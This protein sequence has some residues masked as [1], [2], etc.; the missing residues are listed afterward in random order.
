MRVDVHQHLWTEPLLEALARRRSAPFVRRRDGR[1]RLELP[2]EEA[3]E[4]PGVPEDLHRRHGLLERDGIDRAYVA[5]SPALGV[6]ALPADEADEL[7]TAFAAGLAE[8]GPG[9]HP[10]AAVSLAD[11][12][13]APAALD[14]ALQRQAAGLCVPA[15]ALR[16]PRHVLTLGPTLERL[17][18]SGRPLF[19]HP[20]PDPW[21]AAKRHPITPEWWAPMTGYVTEMHEAWHAWIAAGLASFPSLKVVFAL[22]AGGAPLHLHRLAARGAPG[23]AQRAQHSPQL[24][25]ETSASGPELIEAVGKVVGRGQIVHGS[26]RPVVEPGPIPARLADRLLVKNPARLLGL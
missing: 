25:Y 7:L 6:E 21:A 26:D 19:V 23:L 22:L 4:L 14:Q 2:A 8:A 13:T 10:W 17:E 12:N 15:G 24:F 3:C 18:E 5:L 16:T 1:W 20:G 11:P 9:L